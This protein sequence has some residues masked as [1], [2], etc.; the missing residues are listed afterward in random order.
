M[1]GNV[2]VP[3]KKDDSTAIIEIPICTIGSRVHAM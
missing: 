2:Q 1:L 3:Y